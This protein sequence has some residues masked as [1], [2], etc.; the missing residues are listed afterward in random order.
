MVDAESTEQQPTDTPR[1][2]A[3]KEWRQN[4]PFGAGL[5]MVLAGAVILTPAYLTFDVQGLLISI[6]SLSGVST[7]LIGTLLIASGILTWFGK[8]ARF[9]AGIAAMVLAIVALP[10]SNFGGFILG[11]TLALIGGALALSW[12]PDEKRGKADQGRD[13]STQLVATVVMLGAIAMLLK[14]PPPE[15]LA[16]PPMWPAPPI[17]NKWAVPLPPLLPPTLPDP[18]VVPHPSELVPEPPEVDDL[19][20]PGAGLDLGQA[21]APRAGELAVSNTMEIITADS[22]RLLGN[23]RLSETA[24]TVPSGEVIQSIRLDADHVELDNLGLQAEGVA[25]GL[26]T[27]PGTISTLT[28]NFHIIVRSLTA[29]PGVESGEL[30]PVTIDARNIDDSLLELLAPHSLGLPDV[31]TDELVLRNVS[32]ETFVVR[33]DALKLP[34]SASI[35]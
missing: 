25:V 18:P 13:S 22:V 15:A 5:C 34:A 28:G 9:L 20:A 6:S 29:T 1:G 12:S 23:V 31:V 33:A 4:R 26:T 14:S 2:K 11:T 16:A 27:A 35:S 19:Q 10:T 24:V 7:L 21:P 30:F 8:D 32:L 3:F 17:Q